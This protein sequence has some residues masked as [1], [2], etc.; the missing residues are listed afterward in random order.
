M[1]TKDIILII[2]GGGMAGIFSSG[3]LQV[4]QEK[5]IYPR[6]AA[7]YGTSGGADVGAYFLA[8]Q[9]EI[10]A[11]FYKKYLTRPDFIQKKFGRY[12]YQLLRHKLDHDYPLKYLV[13][14]DFTVRVATQTECTMDMDMLWSKEIPFY[15]KVFC[16][17][18]NNHKYI[19]MEKED[20]FERLKSTSTASPL[21]TYVEIDG[22]RYIDGESISSEIDLEI[23][24]QWKDKKVIVIENRPNTSALRM[25]MSM[26]KIMIAMV[27][28][29]LLFDSKVAWTYFK[30]LWTKKPIAKLKQMDH[31]TVIRSEIRC[32][33]FC[34]DQ[35]LLQRVYEHG[36]RKGKSLSVD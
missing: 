23:A 8:Q 20:F 10:S 19:P 9:C 36:I 5:N 31:V 24:K 2:G 29:W 6:I 32:D 26:P 22:E 25:L 21:S 28:F 14:N 15:A 18:E 7:V 4:L 33:G 35:D 11:H 27:M 12:L 3:V 13:D 1:M 16:L 17:E 30:R 34:R